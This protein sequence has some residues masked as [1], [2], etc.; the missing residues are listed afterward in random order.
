MTA[1]LGWTPAR[2]YNVYRIAI[3]CSLMLLHFGPEQA[4]IGNHLPLLFETTLFVY[5][6]LTLASATLD[7]RAEKR[8]Y[9]AWAQPASLITD[10]TML[11]LVVHA[12]GGLEGGLAVL[13]LVTVAAG[14]ILLRGR[15]GFLIAALATLAMMFEQFYFSIQSL[16]DAP[17]LLT[18]SGLLGIAFFMVSLIIQQITQLLQ[19]SER[20]AKRQRVAIKRLEALNQQIVQRMRTGVVVFDESFRILMANQA[21]NS[22]FGTPMLGNQLPKQLVSRYQRWQDNPLLPLATLRTSEQS[23]VLSPRFAPLETDHELLTLL[24]LEDSA[25]VAQEAQ[26][27]NLASLGRLSATLAHEIR[28][29]L[30]AINHATELLLDGNAS[31]EDQHLLGIIRNHVGRVNGI[32]HDVLDLSRRGRGQAER[33]SLTLFLNELCQQWSLRGYPDERLGKACQSDVE[34]R[35]DSNQLT[36][37]VDNLIRNAFQHGGENCRVTLECGSHEQ[38]G[39]PWLRIRD[40]GKG[41]PTETARHLF[42]PFYTTAN[43]GNGLGLYLCRELCQANQAALDLEDTPNGASFVITFAHPHRQFQ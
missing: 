7:F 22:L 29:P 21:A 17:F 32:I 42:E 28:N 2:I 11:S 24:F 5:L 10:L 15:L 41:I 35:F 31:E 19:Q 12:N 34:V 40:N 26:Q 13:L 30:S 4:L 9:P 43:D 14:N 36:Q 23:P 3:A 6:G 18:E 25:R 8:A 16:S 27:M 39:L 33:F 20:I 37:V 38:T 1:S